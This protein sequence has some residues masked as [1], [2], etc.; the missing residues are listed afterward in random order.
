MWAFGV[1]DGHGMVGHK[2]SQFVKAQ[3]PQAIAKMIRGHGIEDAAQAK[4]NS[5]LP[6]LNV[7]P[8]AAV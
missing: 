5:F 2:V 8:M 7:S 1:M 4:K 3:L 6:N